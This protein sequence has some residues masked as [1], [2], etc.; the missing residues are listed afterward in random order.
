[1]LRKFI[2]TSIWQDGGMN[3]DY[4]AEQL[5]YLIKGGMHIHMYMYRY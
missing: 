3:E 2:H 1:M 4:R 5:K